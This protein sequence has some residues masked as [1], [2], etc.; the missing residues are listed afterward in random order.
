MHAYFFTFGK[1]SIGFH[2]VKIRLR[3]PQD[4]NQS[5][6]NIFALPKLSKFCFVYNHTGLLTDYDSIMKKPQGN[7]SP[8]L[9][10][11]TPIAVNRISSSR[12]QILKLK[13]STDSREKHQFKK[14]HPVIKVKNGNGALS[15]TNTTIELDLR[16][17]YSYTHG[18]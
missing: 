11:T 1:I 18:Q 6:F 2:F 10:V 17:I 3:T 7:I 5:Q 14:L 4:S 16:C 8:R 12:K 9:P 13:S 15:W